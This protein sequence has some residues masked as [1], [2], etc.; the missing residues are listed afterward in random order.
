MALLYGLFVT[1]LNNKHNLGALVVE[2]VLK[3]RK[4]KREGSKM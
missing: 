1:K 2:N 3:R 4:Q